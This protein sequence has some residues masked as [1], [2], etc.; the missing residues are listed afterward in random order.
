MTQEVDHGANIIKMVSDRDAKIRELS[1]DL[2][3]TSGG[4]ADVEAELRELS[5]DHLALKIK[6]RS[7][8]REHASEIALRDER[9]KEVVGFCNE[10]TVEVKNIRAEL[11]SVKQKS[12]PAAALPFVLQLI[13]SA[14]VAHYHAI[15]AQCAIATV[16]K[17]TNKVAREL[18]EIYDIDNVVK[19]PSL[20]RV[21]VRLCTQLGVSPPSRTELSAEIKEYVAQNIDLYVKDPQY[22][23]SESALRQIIAAKNNAAHYGSYGRDVCRMFDW[24]P[25]L[26]AGLDDIED[27]YNDLVEQSVYQVCRNLINDS[28]S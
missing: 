27:D 7:R 28:F 22:A 17:A 4:K 3:V 2:T 18:R 9:I 23:T 8:E 14:G 1:A 21:A 5:L 20:Y 26:A 13:M 6:M 10:Q 11:E 16:N 25:A 24:L 15:I 19:H 12:E